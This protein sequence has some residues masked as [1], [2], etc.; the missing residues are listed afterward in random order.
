MK[1]AEDEY[2]YRLATWLPFRYKV[3]QKYAVIRCDVSQ[4]GY[5]TFN[6]KPEF[7]KSLQRLWKFCTGILVSPTLFDFVLGRNA[8]LILRLVFPVQVSRYL[9]VG[10]TREHEKLIA[11]VQ[12]DALTFT[13]VEIPFRLNLQPHSESTPIYQIITNVILIRFNVYTQLH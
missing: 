5:Y 2:V 3:I 7:Q 1:L 8:T 12:G 6:W 9:L 11:N 13:S 10:Y 4:T